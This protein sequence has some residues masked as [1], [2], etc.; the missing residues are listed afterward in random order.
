MG[1]HSSKLIIKD[2]RGNDNVKEH[3]LKRVETIEKLEKVS[4]EDSPQGEPWTKDKIAEVYPELPIVRGHFVLL[5]IFEDSHEY[6]RDEKGNITCIVKPEDF[7]QREKY[8][9]VVGL[10]VDIGEECYNRNS[11]PWASLG[12][13]H[14]V[15]RYAGHQFT[16]D[17]IPFIRVMDE[18]VYTVVKNPSKVGR[19]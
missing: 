2:K 12:E 14:I 5:R 10:V 1:K 4:F 7:N 15:D 13:W 11:S 17:G 18:K 3:P 19:L 16:Y 6:L 8:L 9:H